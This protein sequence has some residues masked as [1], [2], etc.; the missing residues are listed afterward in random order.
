MYDFVIQGVKRIDLLNSPLPSPFQVAL[1][2]EEFVGRRSFWR[3]QR[4]RE[5]ELTEMESMLHHQ[6]TEGEHLM[7]SDVR[8]QLESIR[9]GE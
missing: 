6:L 5:L 1:L 3:R 7:A 8:S 4:H 9:E 2:E